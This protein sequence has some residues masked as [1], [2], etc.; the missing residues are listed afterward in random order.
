[1]SWIFGILRTN[2]K[3]PLPVKENYPYFNKDKFVVETKEYYFSC[4]CGHNNSFFKYDK[5]K[6]AGWMVCGTGISYNDGSFRL[7][8]FQEWEDFLCEKN[9]D[10][11]D[12]N[13]HFIIVEWSKGK[14]RFRN[15]QLGMR[16]MFFGETGNNF[17]FSTRLDWLIPFVENPEIDFDVYSS[18]WLCVN[19]LSYDCFIKGVKR[20]CPGGQATFYN[21]KYS[22]TYKPWLPDYANNSLNESYL[23]Q[24]EYLTCLGLQEEREVLLGLSGG[25]DSRVLLSIL[26]QHKKDSWGT[27]S[28]GDKN[29]PDAIIAGRLSEKLG[30]KHFTISN[31]YSPDNKDV[32]KFNEFVLQTHSYMIGSLFYEQEHYR[33]IP[34]DCLLIDGG[35]GEYCT[36]SFAKWVSLKGEGA[37]LARDTN[38]ILDLIHHTKPN[39][40]IH[41]LEKKMTYSCR[42]QIKEVSE[43]MPPIKDIGVG[44]WVDIFTI[45][46]RTGNMGPP[47]QARLDNIIGNYMPFLQ[48]SFLR[49]VFTLPVRFRAQNKVYKL[50]LQKGNSTL[51]QIPLVK[52]MSIIPFT[53]NTYLSFILGKLFER[54]QKSKTIDYSQLFLVNNKE[55]VMDTLQSKAVKEYPYYDYNKIHNLVSEYYNGQ[56]GL[57]NG[58]LWWLT[59][60]VW[61]R[62]LHEK[63]KKLDS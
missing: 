35:K 3:A 16:D 15:D 33:S 41:D 22:H 61:R 51:S 13:G 39:I 9:N 10:V 38:K 36:R 1:M 14:L 6:D 49:K 45:R 58:V 62:A 52:D 27:Y 18:S 46:T 25:L 56:K 50:I 5:D 30:F 29:F 40:F 47:T 20:L 32:E 26:L 34:R 31:L 11:N 54:F 24:I 42:Q 57:A 17:S 21:G 55:Y 59:F 4:G 23:K 53:H 43:M 28:F 60:D 48:P 2:D 44:N 7:M 8:G 12:L 19:P 37:I 63:R